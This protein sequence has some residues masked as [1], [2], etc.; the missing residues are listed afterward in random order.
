MAGGHRYEGGKEGGKEGKWED[1]VEAA[2]PSLPSSMG[3]DGCVV[4]VA[5]KDRIGTVGTREGRRE[6]WR[7]GRREGG[8]N[9]FE[10]AGGKYEKLNSHTLVSPFPPS[11]PP[12]L[13]FSPQRLKKV[14]TLL[15]RK[16]G[17][18]LAPRV[19]SAVTHVLVA[20]V[21]FLTAR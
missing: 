4:F 3:L 8:N 9:W 13:L 1:D 6:G 2:F 7:K 19:D 5:G 16:G 10:C 21:M 15:V 12:S 18:A 14:I 17:A 11:L 20:D